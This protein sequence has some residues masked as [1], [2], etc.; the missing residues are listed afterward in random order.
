MYGRVTRLLVTPLIRSLSQILGPHPLLTYLDNFRYPLAG[1]FAISA[2]L[3][4]SIRIP[5]DWGLEIGILAEVHR[6]TSARR[7]CQVELAESFE[8]KHRDLAVCGSSE[9][10]MRMAVDI[11]GTIFRTLAGEGVVITPAMLTSLKLTYGRAAREMFRRY[12]DDARLNG[13]VF[14]GIEESLAIE[15]FVDAMELAAKAFLK[16]RLSAALIP[17]WSRVES[18]IPGFLEDL[19]EQVEKDNSP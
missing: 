8:H 10:L 11:A 19:R 18:A 2:S 9:G 12:Q 6:N 3:A 13:L 15:T 17:A 5:G 7:I 4:G 1:E 14:D 16:D